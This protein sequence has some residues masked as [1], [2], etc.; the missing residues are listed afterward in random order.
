MNLALNPPQDTYNYY[1]INNTKARCKVLEVINSLLFL[2]FKSRY[3]TLYMAQTNPLK[4]VRIEYILIFDS[5]SNF[6]ENC[7]IK[8]G[9]RS[10][11]SIVLLEI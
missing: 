6:S 11:H 2:S 7:T 9:Y 8:P 3:K 1:D 10:D 4:Q 5:L